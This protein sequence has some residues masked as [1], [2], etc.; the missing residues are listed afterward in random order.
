MLVTRVVYKKKRPFPGLLL[1]LTTLCIFS[2]PL[3]YAA[4]QSWRGLCDGQWVANGLGY[5]C[6]P[7]RRPRRQIQPC[8]SGY[9]VYGT[10]C[11]KLG[12]TPCNGGSWAC[13]SGYQ[14]T[15]VGCIPSGA[16]QCPKSRKGYCKA[17]YICDIDDKSG[18]EKCFSKTDHDKLVA[19]RFAEAERLSKERLENVLSLRQKEAEEKN[20]ASDEEFEK[21]QGVGFQEAVKT[22]QDVT[23]RSPEPLSSEASKKA[24]DYA[25]LAYESYNNG[26]SGIAA[27]NGWNRMDRISKDSGFQ[28]DV[29]RKGD[30][31]VIAYRGTD[32]N[33][34]VD[35]K[36]N[37]S[38][39]LN[40]LAAPEQYNQALDLVDDVRERF[41]DAAI[42]LT[43]H[44]LGGGLASYAGYKRSI[45]TVTFNA[46]RNRYSVFGINSEQTNFIVQNDLTSDP[47]SET[48]KF[49]GLAIGTRAYLPGRTFALKP[50]SVP[51]DGIAAAAVVNHDMELLLNQLSIQSNN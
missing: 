49:V 43:G 17:P 33:S 23:K 37:A 31:I 36:A 16:S 5:T 19:E 12:S 21:D 47:R 45:P 1:L 13:A 11:L 7:R 50:F 32:T 27:Q 44:S 15:D 39:L 2:E 30:R 20:R 6:I 9:Y 41:P 26:A 42:S 51:S 25:Q 40:P 4:G 22:I 3:P 10:K 38:A 46:A 28:A 24:L 18:D 8:P 48:Y 29:Y 35:W 34:G 14:C